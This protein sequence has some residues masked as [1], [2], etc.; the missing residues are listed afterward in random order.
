MALPTQYLTSSK[1]VKGILQA[2][3]AGQA[4]KKFTTAFLQGL[5]YKNVSDRLIIGVLKALGI[6]NTNGE[7][8]PRYFAFLDQSQGARVLADG[9]REAYADL[10]QVNA[11]ANELSQ[12]EIKNKFKTLT[13]GR[14]SDSVL[15]KM[16]T[17][18]K[19]LSGLADFSGE[20]TQKAKTEE[21]TEESKKPKSPLSSKP[22]GALSLS[23]LVYNIQIHLPESRD[24]AVY[25][26]LFRSL[27]EHLL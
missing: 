23:G 25:D 16:A 9:I 1:N 7:P 17:T 14:G 13:Q 26:A 11:K 6:L 5:G 15:D 4:P 12:T 22:E 8:T 19:T 18:F 24:P 10:F 21:T 2:I 20:Q 27:R 3:Q